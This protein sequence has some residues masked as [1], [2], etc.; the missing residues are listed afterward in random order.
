MLFAY[1]GLTDY[2]VIERIQSSD[3]FNG[4]MFFICGNVLFAEHILMPG[5]LFD[6]C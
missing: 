1:G 2:A 6:D 3:M 4:R 5:I